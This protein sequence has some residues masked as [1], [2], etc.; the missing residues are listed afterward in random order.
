MI[1][2]PSQTPS[3]PDATAENSVNRGG[4]ALLSQ[5]LEMPQKAVTNIGEELAHFEQ[6]LKLYSAFREK[7]DLTAAALVKSEGT[8]SGQKP[9]GEPALPQKALLNRTGHVEHFRTVPHRPQLRKGKLIFDCPNCLRQTFVPASLGGQE[10]RC[11]ECCGAIKAPSRKRRYAGRTRVNDVRSLCAEHHFPPAVAPARKL[12]GPLS[13]V[14]GAGGAY[15]IL[16]GI[17]SILTHHPDLTPRTPV[18]QPTLAVAEDVLEMKPQNPQAPDLRSQAEQTVQAFVKATSLSEKARYVLDSRRVQP[19]LEDFYAEAAQPHERGLLSVQA[20]G[21]GYLNGSRHNHAVTDVV[22]A[23][24]DGTEETFHVVH[25]EQPRIE[26]EQS[27]GYV[28]SAWK[29]QLR[30]G[31]LVQLRVLASRSDYFNYSYREMRP[32]YYCVKMIH[33]SNGDLLGYGYVPKDSAE[34]RE[35]WASL[36]TTDDQS[37]ACQVEL[38]ADAAGVAKDQFRI[39]RAHSE[40]WRHNTSGVVALR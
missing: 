22:C 21:S 4:F 6:F 28:P 11:R 32:N 38:R 25:A 2:S 33:P 36:D 10:V 34:G 39:T 5:S 9:A 16:F 40:H 27:V 35:L 20:T 31:S 23:Y 26:W 19:L 30:E 13:L 1:S 12:S 15:A 8:R 37:V 3:Q 17:F 14:L 24:E 18:I 29:Q 7:T